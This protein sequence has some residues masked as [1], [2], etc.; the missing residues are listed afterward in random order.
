MGIQEETYISPSTVLCFGMCHMLVSSLGLITVVV[1]H[2]NL[3]HQNLNQLRTRGALGLR[4]IKGS[5]DKGGSK[6][7]H[8]RWFGQVQRKPEPTQI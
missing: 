7:Y 6:Q 4:R 3:L 5:S 1:G 2:K 8:L